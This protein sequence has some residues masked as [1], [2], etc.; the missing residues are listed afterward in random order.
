MFR[1]VYYTEDWIVREE[2]Y[3]DFAEA[4]NAAGAMDCPEWEEEDPVDENGEPLSRFS[5]VT[6]SEG[7]YY[8]WY[9]TE[10]ERGSEYDGDDPEILKIIDKEL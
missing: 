3:D 4:V 6:D 9:N 2:E 1:V 8:I 7:I 5:G 10:G